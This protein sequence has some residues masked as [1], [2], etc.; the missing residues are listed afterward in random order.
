ML[1]L[2]AVAIFGG[3]LILGLAIAYAVTRNRRYLRIAWLALQVLLLLAIAY[4]LV[5]V[6][7]RLLLI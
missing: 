6:L 7:S 1:I 2:R 3:L 4:G 5:Y